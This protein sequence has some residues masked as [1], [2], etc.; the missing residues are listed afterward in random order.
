MISLDTHNHWL[1]QVL[2]LYIIY[3]RD[4][5]RLH[6]RGEFHARISP[7]ALALLPQLCLNIHHITTPRARKR[8]RAACLCV[9]V[10]R[11]VGR[12]GRGGMLGSCGSLPHLTGMLQ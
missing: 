10:G 4:V 5:Y 3:S 9:G 2:W 8:R 1:E 11:M 7:P 12:M 6:T